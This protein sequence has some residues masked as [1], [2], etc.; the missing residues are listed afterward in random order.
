MP[1]LDKDLDVIITDDGLCAQC[2]VPSSTPICASCA[3]KIAADTG[4]KGEVAGHLVSQHEIYRQEMARRELAV[5]HL[6][7]YVQRMMPQYIPGWVHWDIAAR[8]ERFLQ[9]VLDGKQPR[10]LLNLPPRHGKSLLTSQF[11]PAW[12]LGKH[13]DIEFITT[14]HT[15]SLAVQFSRK[16]RGILDTD[17]HQLLFP[18]TGVDPDNRN[19]QGWKTTEGGGYLPAGVGGSITGHGAHIFVIDDYL[20]NSEDAQSATIREKHDQ[21]Y[22]STAYSRLAPNGGMLIVATRWHLDD[23]AGRR[24]VAMKEDPEAD[25]FEI[26][27]YPAIAEKDEFRTKT[28]KIIHEAYPGAKLLRQK[29]DA[30]HEERW[31]LKKL[32]RIKR[33]ALPLDWAA[34]YQQNPKASETANFKEEDFI[35]YPYGEEPDNLVH[36]STWDLAVGLLQRNDRTVG[37]HAGVDEDGD[38]WLIDCEIGRIETD[39]MVDNILDSYR[40]FNQDIIGI[41]K[42]QIEKS[43]GPFLNKEIESSGLHGIN[44]EGLPPGNRDK[45]AR[46]KSIIGWLARGRVHAPKDAPWWDEF[47]NELLEFPVGKHDDIVDALAWMGYLLDHMRQATQKKEEHNDP[48]W[49]KK[50][51]AQMGATIIQSG[52]RKKNW[53]TR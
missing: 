8:L 9:D 38:L 12:V 29:G 13:P 42:G 25:Q 11:W 50:A 48:E 33:T 37:M 31:P 16:V 40:R 36:Y 30:L 7:P 46:S 19:A 26:V 47:I 28:G 14:S 45:V 32:L 10:L 34:L 6:I 15:A 39:T 4:A 22:S 3:A 53:K 44:V 51:K 49:L 27:L 35:D 17:E 23:L 5:R 41:E 24:L 21:W 1:H 52:R 43:I 20:K 2:H 18:G